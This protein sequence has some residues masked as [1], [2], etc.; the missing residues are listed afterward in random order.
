MTYT[1]NLEVFQ[2]PIDLLLHLIT[3]RRVDI[4]DVSLAAITDEYLAA[5][6]TMEKLNLE[7]A[8]GF[9]VVAATLLELK[10]ARLLPRSS[11]EVEGDAYLLEERDLLLSRLCE[12][13]TFRAAGEWMGVGLERGGLLHPRQ[14]S[15]EPRFLEQAAPPDLAIGLDDLLEGA[16]R[17]F[18]PR[19]EHAID[20]AHITPVK[21]SVREAVEELVSTLRITGSTTFEQLCAGHPDRIQVVVRFL[22]LLELFKAGAVELDQ[23]T[24][25]GDIKATWNG[26]AAAEDVLAE[27]DEYVLEEGRTR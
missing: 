22:A 25:F 17:A 11:S 2:G 14:V 8:T 16:A 13:A 21:A 9:L 5:L 1:V 6:R 3:R 18:R 4:Y 23:A 7:V 15:L 12:C 24:R 20:T 26:G 27:I 10:S 19:S